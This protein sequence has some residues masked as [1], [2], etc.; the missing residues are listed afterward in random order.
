MS[1]SSKSALSLISTHKGY[2][3]QSNALSTIFWTHNPRL[4]A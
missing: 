1:D 2:S 4:R 3:G